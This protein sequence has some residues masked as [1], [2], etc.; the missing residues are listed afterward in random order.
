MNKLVLLETAFSLSFTRAT[1]ETPTLH[2]QVR[3]IHKVGADTCDFNF[4]SLSL[5]HCG[6]MTSQ[7]SKSSPVL[8]VQTRKIDHGD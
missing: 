1:A 3:T 6:R 5:E 7:S 8:A 4:R 2:V